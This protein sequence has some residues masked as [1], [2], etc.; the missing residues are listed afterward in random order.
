MSRFDRIVLVSFLIFLTLPSVMHLLEAPSLES[1]IEQR[2]LADLP[3]MPTSAR[4]VSLLPGQI[5][6]YLNDH[7]GLRRVMVLLYS[8]LLRS[9][10]D[11]V[12]NKVM[13]GRDGWL[14]LK[15]DAAIAQV[16]GRVRDEERLIEAWVNLLKRHADRLGSR[17]VRFVFVPI[18]NKHAIYTEYLPLW[19]QPNTDSMNQRE[20]LIRIARENKINAVDLKPLLTS[21]KRHRKTYYRTDTHWAETTA[22][23]SYQA[24]YSAAMPNDIKFMLHE[25]DL[26]WHGKFFSG[27]LANML[28]L[29]GIL[30][31]EVQRA[32]FVGNSRVTARSRISDNP[33]GGW[34][35]SLVTTSSLS[36]A[37]RVMVVGDSFTKGSH[38]FWEESTSRFV[39]THHRGG[40][41]DMTL[42]DRFKPD[43][44]I[45]QIIERSLAEIEPGIPIK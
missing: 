4:A 26:E 15:N 16:T 23:R 41:F 33:W 3:S 31:E 37:P 20:I 36:A 10:G 5:D 28:N 12:S 43:I 38:M 42:V 6:A 19:L 21:L 35:N 2:R 45:F 39:W 25:D 7:F 14:F 1:S 30:R 13:N 9:I 24:I 8:R 11:S 29:N 17:G 18:P 27:D 32:R 34:R 40:D 22:F 44:V